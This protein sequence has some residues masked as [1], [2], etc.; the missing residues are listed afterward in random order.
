MSHTGPSG[1]E[2]SPLRELTDDELSDLG[3]V[4]E[5]N[6]GIVD[7]H[8]E[9][10]GFQLACLSMAIE[11]T[12]LVIPAVFGLPHPNLV[13]NRNADPAA[14]NPSEWFYYPQEQPD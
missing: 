10:A 12:R 8:K 1:E 5:L 2:P 6:L 14:V 3:E 11:D 9:V 4:T 7:P 13:R